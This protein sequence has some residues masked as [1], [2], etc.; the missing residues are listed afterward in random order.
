MGVSAS[1]FD[2]SVIVDALR[3][4]EIL[5]ELQVPC[6]HQIGMPDAFYVELA[7]MLRQN[8]VIRTLKS[9]YD[10]PFG[11]RN[12]SMVALAMLA[13]EPPDE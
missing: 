8:D 4:N 5:K 3:R 12:G 6:F 1:D 11:W 9:G 2:F 10:A 7:H 13:P